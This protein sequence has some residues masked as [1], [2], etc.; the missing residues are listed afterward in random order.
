M[1]TPLDGNPNV[2]SPIADK[3]IQSWIKKGIKTI[4]HLYVNGIFASFLQLSEL[5]DLP[6]HNL[7]K[8]L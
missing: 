5:F 1:N 6:K 8:Y 2:P 3:T 4:G 7:V